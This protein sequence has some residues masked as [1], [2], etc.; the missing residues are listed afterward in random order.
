[1]RDLT[2]AE[3]STESGL[4]I[5]RHKGEF[6]QSGY[7]ERYTSGEG[8]LEDQFHRGYEIYGESYVSSIKAGFLAAE[9]CRSLR[10]AFG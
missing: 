3:T 6:S 9:N 1:V 7:A 5:A 8:L 2:A 4:R 10:L